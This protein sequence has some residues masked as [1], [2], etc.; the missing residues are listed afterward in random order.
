VGVYYDHSV[1]QI[2]EGVVKM[3]VAIIRNSRALRAY[4][5]RNPLSKNP[6]MYMPVIHT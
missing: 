4:N 2:K 6:Y 5:I 1:R 3:G